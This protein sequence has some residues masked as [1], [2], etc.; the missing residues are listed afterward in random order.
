MQDG[1]HDSTSYDRALRQVKEIK[2]FY[3][4]LAVYIII[5]TMLFLINWFTSPTT[6]WFYW[7]V[8]FWGIGLLV[9]AYS[10]FVE[11]GFFGRDW[12]ERKVRE[13]M[14]KEKKR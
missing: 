1:D 8:I 13:I 14:E 2:D 5:N 12:E 6:W 4:H 11:E 10:T 7:V 3:G 9:H